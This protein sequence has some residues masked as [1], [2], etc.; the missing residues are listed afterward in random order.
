MYIRE[1]VR[2]GQT[3]GAR[4]GYPVTYEIN[5]TLELPLVVVMV[6]LLCA[7]LLRYRP[8]K[9][10]R[11]LGWIITADILLLLC[12]L[13]LWTVLGVREQFDA[14]RV[15]WAADFVLLSVVAVLFHFFALT[16]IARNTDVPRWLYWLIVPLAPVTV[17]SYISSL[18]TGAFYVIG[19]DA[20]YSEGPY[21]VVGVLLRLSPL[22]V[23]MVITLCYTRRMRKRDA[24]LLL[25]YEAVPIATV[26]LDVIYRLPLTVMAIS[27]LLMVEYVAF[28]MERDLLIARQQERMA[29]QEKKLTESRT[30]IMLSQI[31]PHFLYNSIS[32]IMMLCREDADRAVDALAD[33]SEYLRANMQAISL[34]TTVPFTRELEHIRTYVRLEELR[35]HQRLRVVYDLEEENFFLPTLTIQPL[36]ENAVK[37]GIARRQEGGTVTV[38]TRRTPDGVWVVVDDDGVGFD[39][40]TPPADGRDHVGIANVR[41]RLEVMCGGMLIIRS[42]PGRGTRANVFI[43]DRP[44][45]KKE[46]EHD[47]HRR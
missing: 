16:T 39:P 5:A 35:F 47:H 45:E 8:P 1:S 12:D 23:D 27:F 32:S 21:A 4:G 6:V 10:Q 33:F 9:G 38:S 28:S 3:A 34:E 36:I 2:N 25:I 29:L 46:E 19:A 15:L 17:F 42:Q 30:K 41:S 44:S 24:V 26:I 40:D 18:R 31:Q 14:V 11:I 13:R 22:I 43:P 7:D 37:H 20:D